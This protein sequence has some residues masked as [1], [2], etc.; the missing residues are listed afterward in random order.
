MMRKI[1]KIHRILGLFLALNFLLLGLT[2]VVLIWRHELSDRPLSIQQGQ[3]VS[4]KSSLV[5]IENYLASEFSNKKILSIFKGDDEDLHA[6][7]TDLGVV[8]FKGATR[9]RF[10]LSGEVLEKQL[11]KKDSLLDTILKLHRELLFGGKGKILV[12]ILGV[13]FLF[14]LITG[15]VIAGK[16]YRNVKKMNN[17]ILQGRIHKIIGVKTFTWLFIVTFTGTMLAFNS[18]L[19]GLFL[20]ENV[21]SQNSFGNVVENAKYIKASQVFEILHEK[22]PELEYDFISFPDNEFSVPNHFV[23]LMESETSHKIA[24]INAISGEFVKLVSLPWYLELLIL[25]EPLHF[26]DY[27]GVILKIIWSILGLLASFIPL[28]GLIIFGYRKKFLNTNETK[29]NGESLRDFNIDLVETFIPAIFIFAIF[30][31]EDGYK[32]ILSGLFFIFLVYSWRNFL[33]FLVSPFR[34]GT[35]KARIHE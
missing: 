30:L 31:I 29:D 8:K 10:D 27:G 26:G 6:R 7:V 18:T 12:G 32:A 35:K 9:L 21:R 22:L 11:I 28:S 25:S 24:Y 20:R 4:E 15:A 13:F 5:K 3:F 16:F 14:A 23:V 34:I 19:I 1:L 2:G 17:R 33:G